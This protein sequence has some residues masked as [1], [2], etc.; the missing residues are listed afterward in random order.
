MRG[1]VNINGIDYKYKTQYEEFYGN[2]SSSKTLSVKYKKLGKIFYKKAVIAEWNCYSWLW[3]VEEEFDNILDSSER[4]L[5]DLIIKTIKKDL[6][7][8]KKVKQKE[9]YEKARKKVLYNK[10][11]KM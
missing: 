10:F 3:R 2:F 8:T 1:I 7:E 5:L 4:V 9:L 6:L 11:N